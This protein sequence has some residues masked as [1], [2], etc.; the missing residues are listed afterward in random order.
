[1]PI[2]WHCMT[3]ES[4]H[5]LAV[6]GNNCRC[7][8]EFDATGARVSVCEAHTM[9]VQQMTSGPGLRGVSG[10]ANLRSVALDDPGGMRLRP[11][12]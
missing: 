10:I 6:V 4:L 7:I 12:A 2:I 3:Q 11:T 8:F 9:L 1:M 5:L